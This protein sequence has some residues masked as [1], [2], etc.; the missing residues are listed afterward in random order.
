MDA[1]RAILS[2]RSCGKFS[3]K[4]VPKELIEKLILA[5]RSAPTGL[6]R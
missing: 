3:D 6:N 4:D 2:G 5:G 1:E